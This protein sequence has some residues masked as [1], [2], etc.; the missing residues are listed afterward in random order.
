M[1]MTDDQLK[2]ALDALTDDG[3]TFDIDD[4][5]QLRLV[6][7]HDDDASIND[8]DCYGTISWVDSYRSGR[9]RR[10]SEMDGAAR[11]LQVG[12]GEWVWWQPP[13]DMIHTGPRSE[14]AD[15][16]VSEQLNV[17]RQHVTDLVESGFSV[18]GVQLHELVLDSRG[19]EHWVLVDAD[20]LGGVDSTKPEHIREYLSDM[21]ENLVTTQ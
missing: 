7:E 12:R 3:D 13:A 11:K 14:T 21:I 10:P 20:Y 5:H 4:T 2:D 18:V 19:H 1:T 9:A 17:L 6:I 8:Y 15:A 16:S